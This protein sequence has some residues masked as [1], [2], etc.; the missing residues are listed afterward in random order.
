MNVFLRIFRIKELRTSI[1]FV[2]GMLVIFRLAAHVPVPGVD[3]SALSSLFQGNQVLGLLN[4]FSGGTLENFSIVALGIAPY[5]TASIIFQLLAMIVPSFEEMQKEEAGRRKINQYTRMA[6]VPLAFLQGYGIINLLASQ[7]QGLIVDTGWLTMLLIMT[8]MTAGTIFLMWLGELISERNIGNGI[9]ILIFAG[10]IAGLPTTFQQVVATF[11]RTQVFDMLLILALVIITI[12]AVVIINEAQRNIP[13]Q[14][15]RMQQGARSLGGVAS[16][17]P[18]RVNMGGMI[19]IIFAVSI[20][21]FPPT[22]AQ[23]FLRAKTEWIVNAAQFTI[24][25]FTNQLFYGLIFFLLVFGFTFFYSGVVFHPDRIAENLQKQGG[26]VPGIR[27][28]RPTAEYLQWVTNRILLLGATYLA[29]IAVL[30]IVVQ[31]V[32]G[33]AQLV[34]GGASVIIIVGVVIDLIKQIQAQL[35]MH[36][37]ER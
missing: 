18:L 24:D 34:V 13:I 22:M 28:G 15:A 10:I 23:F 8:T 27:P 20:I 7:A 19:P 6:T 37:Y 16:N 29:V 11:D 1:L 25:I 36:E 3:P 32:T 17:L 9:S 21:L 30:P 35:S 2:L 4:L 31:Q 33:T 5:I 12:A 14:Y 26:F